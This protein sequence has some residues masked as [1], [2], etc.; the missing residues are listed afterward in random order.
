MNP[1]TRPYWQDY[2]LDRH[3]ITKLN[4]YWIS[5]LVA[6]QLIREYATQNDCVAACLEGIQK[7]N[8]TVQKV[9]C[10]PGQLR[11]L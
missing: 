6:N 2:D 9:H 11:T 5:L 3:S 7:A 4:V 1:N 10:L 8:K